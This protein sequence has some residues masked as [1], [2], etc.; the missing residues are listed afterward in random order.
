MA[1][2]KT[3]TTL[4]G[5]TA[6]NAYHRVEGVTL[7]Q[8]NRMTFQVRS[9]K[10]AEFPFF[11]DVTHATAFDLNGPNPIEQAYL[12]LKSLPEFADAVDC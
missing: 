10:Q 7:V 8:K 9:Y 6:T 5:F 2:Q 4:E 1:L 3:T 12:H 11:S